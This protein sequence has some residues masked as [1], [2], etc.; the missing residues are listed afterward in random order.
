[1]PKHFS[2]KNLVKAVIVNRTSQYRVGVFNNHC[3]CSFFFELLLGH[4]PENVLE[5]MKKFLPK[6]THFGESD[7]TEQPPPERLSRRAHASF[8]S[9]CRRV[10]HEGSSPR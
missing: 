8:G 7:V 1:M 4:F 9:R 6:G 5:K 10:F 2:K 3:F